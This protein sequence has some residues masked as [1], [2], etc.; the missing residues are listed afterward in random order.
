MKNRDV[1]FRIWDTNKSIMVYSDESEDDHTEYYG[2]FAN[3]FHQILN[4]LKEDKK[5]ILL[6]Y[7]GL[8]DKN[9]KEIYDG[10]IV[11]YLGEDDLVYSLLGIVSIGEYSTHA[12]EFK[13]YGVRVKR[14]DIDSYFGL[15]GRP[16]EFAII[17][18]IFK[19][20][21]LIEYEK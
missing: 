11:K 16:D 9:G 7:T 6:E 1:K 13:H 15:G 4:D 20:K 18:N 5:Y 12:G 3:I 17:G 21:D 2:C 10:D 8:K 19:N 14:I